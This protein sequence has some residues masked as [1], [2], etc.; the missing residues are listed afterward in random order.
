[1]GRLFVQLGGLVALALGIAACTSPIKH[2]HGNTVYTQVGIWIQG[3]KHAT[4]NYGR[5]W[6]IPVNTKVVIDDTSSSAI[7]FTIPE[8][9]TEVKRVRIMNVPKYSKEDIHGIYDR[10][11]GDTRVSLE[12]FSQLE[13][14]AIRNG[15]IAEGMRRSAVLIARGYPPAHQTPSLEDDKWTFW[16]H[17]WGRHIVHFEDGRVVYVDK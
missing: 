2:T 17:K 16:H 11:F 12:K 6:F 14:E 10:Y 5:G 13:K 15:E 8:P 7:V 1:M 3:D 9:T 4:T